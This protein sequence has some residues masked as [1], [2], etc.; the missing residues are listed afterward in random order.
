MYIVM[1]TTPNKVTAQMWK[2][3]IEAGGVPS[4]IWP[5]RRHRELGEAA[6]YVVLVPLG[7]DHVVEE[8]LRN[9]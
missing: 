4:M 2:D 3:L 5:D 1:R 6:P 9:S 8:A 7:K